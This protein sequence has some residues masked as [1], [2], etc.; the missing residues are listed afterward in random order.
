MQKTVADRARDTTCVPHPKSGLC[1]RCRD[2]HD[3]Q[4]IPS[5]I[6]SCILC[7]GQHL[8]GTGSCKV[9]NSATKRRSPPP[10][11]T[12]FPTKEDFPSLDKTHP[13]T[14]AWSS[15]AVGAGGT[16]SQDTELQASAGRGE[17]SSGQPFIFPPNSLSNF[18]API[19]AHAVSP[20]S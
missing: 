17:S 16:T 2:K 4:D 6:P 10:Q 19:F 13:S 9:R 1:S 7:G 18:T 8:T 14:S 12:T 15:G 20:G 11:K 3:R 5:C